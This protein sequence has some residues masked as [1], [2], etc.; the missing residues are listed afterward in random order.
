MKCL[1]SWVAFLER[2]GT[3]KVGPHGGSLGHWVWMNSWVA[4]WVLKEDCY[5]R[6]KL[7]AP[8]SRCSHM[9]APTTIYRDLATGRSTRAC[10]FWTWI[11]WNVRIS[12]QWG[13]LRGDA[14]LTV[15]IV[16]TAPKIMKI[17]F[18]ACEE[19][20]WGGEKNSDP[21]NLEF[22]LL[23]LLPI[24]Y[25]LMGPLR[26]AASCIPALTRI[27]AQQNELFFLRP[28]QTTLRKPSFPPL[29]LNLAAG[30]RKLFSL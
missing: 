30:L 17:T 11:L 21:S 6:R 28:K 4:S 22:A 3:I 5:K 13:I 2:N 23:R 25:S 20:Y 1:V 19:C 18:S 27:T 12:S 8:T 7:D 16:D 24:L 14:M 29:P 10:L 9:L 26:A 15:K